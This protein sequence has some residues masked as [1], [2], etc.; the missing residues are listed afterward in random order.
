MRAV[1]PAFVPRNHRIEQAIEAASGGD[2]GP[3]EDLLAAITRP[4]QEQPERAAW[5]AAP[6]PHE[7]VRQTFCGT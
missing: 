6:E 3:F 4:H 7:V 2:L 1:N 5:A